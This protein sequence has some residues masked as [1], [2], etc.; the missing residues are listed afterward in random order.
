MT[1]AYQ[2]LQILTNADKCFVSKGLITNMPTTTYN[3]RTL[4]T[5]YTWYTNKQTSHLISPPI[6]FLS[7]AHSCRFVHHATAYEGSMQLMLPLPLRLPSSREPLSVTESPSSG[8]PSSKTK[9]PSKVASARA[10]A[11]AEP[12]KYWPSWQHVKQKLIISRICYCTVHNYPC[13]L[14]AHRPR[15]RHRRDHHR[16]RHTFAR[17]YSIFRTKRGARRRRRRRQIPHIAIHS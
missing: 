12:G 2:C 5:T 4:C 1:H 13:S 16:P 10:T 14:S 17:V 3:N 9:L 8:G 7:L 6:L 15:P 11:M